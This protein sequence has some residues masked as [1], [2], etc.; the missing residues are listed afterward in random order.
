[1]REVLVRLGQE[2]AASHVPSAVGTLSHGEPTTNAHGSEKASSSA[3]KHRWAPLTKVVHSFQRTRGPRPAEPRS[4]PPHPRPHS[5][6]DSP[7]VIHLT[8]DLLDALETSDESD[9]DDEEDSG[10]EKSCDLDAVESP[11]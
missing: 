3:K 5:C 2:L 4:S 6:C 11:V 7:F 1:M 9:Y 8:P 10:D